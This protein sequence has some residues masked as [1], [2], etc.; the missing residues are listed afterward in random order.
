MMLTELTP[1]P[2]EALPHEAFKAHLRLGTGFEETGLQQEVLAH[3]LRAA[4]AA[5]EARTGKVLLARDYDLELAAWTGIW[6]DASG[7][8][9][10]PARS[11]SVSLPLAPVQ[12]ID[13]MTLIF[14]DGSSELIAADRYQLIPDNQQPRLSGRNGALPTI[15]AGAS[16]RLRL[17][18][19]L[20]DSWAAMPADLAQAV[21]ML[22]AH[23]YEYRDDMR[24]QG[25]C[26]PFGVSSLIERYRSLRLSLGRGAGAPVHR[27]EL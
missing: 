14:A 20:A 24:L 17:R 7:Q 15:P 18:A 9:F 23:Y 19:G 2:E 16:M 8:S 26:M 5:I 22:A 10:S 27:G 12:Q 13:S 3:F 6:P 1:I 25:G 4:I 11:Q 21:L